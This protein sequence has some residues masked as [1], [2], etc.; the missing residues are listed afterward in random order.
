MA[1]RL[2]ETAQ[3]FTKPLTHPYE[4]SMNPWK[5]GVVTPQAAAKGLLVAG[6]AQWVCFVCDRWKEKYL[7]YAWP[8]TYELLEKILKKFPYNFSTK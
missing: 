6:L 8:I 3:L 7:M 2:V 1:D 4:S 5:Q